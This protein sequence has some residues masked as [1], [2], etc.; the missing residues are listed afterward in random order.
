M[1]LTTLKL[2]EVDGKAGCQDTNDF[3]VD[4]FFGVFVGNLYLIGDGDLVSL[5]EQ[6][7]GVVFKGVSWNTAHRNRLGMVLVAS[8]KLNLKH[9]RGRERV[10]AKKFVK[11]AE[12]EKQKGLGRFIFETPILVIKRRLPGRGFARRRNTQRHA[13]SL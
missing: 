12:P 3:S 9:G 1:G 4:E 6:T 11:V 10:V 13:R 5:G 2:F 7:L 8:R